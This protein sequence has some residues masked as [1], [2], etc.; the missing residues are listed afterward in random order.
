MQGSDSKKRI[1]AMICMEC[2]DLLR[3]SYLTAVTPMGRVGLGV[4]SC[5][6]FILLGIK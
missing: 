6:H 1:F 4:S 5:K 2:S 3:K